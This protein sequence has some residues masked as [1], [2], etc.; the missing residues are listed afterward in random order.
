MT[1]HVFVPD[2]RTGRLFRASLSRR[3]FL[4]SAMASGLAAAATASIGLRGARADERPVP[5][6]SALR[7][8]G[9][10][11]RA[12]LVYL[13]GGPSHIDTFDPKPGRPT[14]GE[15]KTVKTPIPGVHLSE[16]L[17]RVASR[18]LDMAVIRGMSSN[19]G[20]HTR[21]RTLVH[22]GYPPEAT[23]EHPSFG[24]SVAHEIGA[25]ELELPAYVNIGPSADG[26]AFLGVQNAPFVVRNATSKIENLDYHKSVGADRVERRL[27]L[28][29]FM[30]DRFGESHGKDVTAGHDAMFE[31]AK[32]MV[33]SPLTVAFDVSKEPE[34]ARALYGESQ[35]GQG[36][37][38][39]RRLLE[40]GVPFVE[41]VLGGW[42]THDDNFTRVSNLCGQLDAGLGGLLEDLSERGMLDTTLVACF[43][44]FGRTPK[45]NARGGRDH[46]ARAW[47]AV[48]AG[49]GVLGGQV[50]GET[51]QD[52]TAPKDR[53]VSPADLHASFWHAFGV[54]PWKEF[55]AN[56]RP[57]TLTPKE[58]KIVRELFV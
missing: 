49:G 57:I 5:Y 18:M 50:I 46:Y 11:K 32:K 26:P 56:E 14:G 34:K 27:E 21:A 55:Y 23:V 15:F 36:C 37:L 16:H 4:G 43:G 47:S 30:Q 39:A 3:G 22:T 44:E 54:D 58:G 35:F 2:N 40:A 31:K 45:I 9:Q 6:G 17:P 10:A 53:P 24:C 42:D 29:D 7:G 25:K 28:L 12:V 48:V 19:E 13:A 1:D 33:D 8:H 41:V 20:N 52:G 38:M 51:D